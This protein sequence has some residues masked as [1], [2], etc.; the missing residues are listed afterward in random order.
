MSRNVYN[1]FGETKGLFFAELN[2]LIAVFMGH[3][4]KNAEQLAVKCYIYQQIST[5]LPRIFF[6]KIKLISFSLIFDSNLTTPPPPPTSLKNYITTSYLLFLNPC[7]S[8]DHFL[9]GKAVN[10][11]YLKQTTNMIKKKILKLFQ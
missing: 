8:R 10:S 3:S 2:L 1:L 6:L 5:H 7:S 11:N 4:R 9:I